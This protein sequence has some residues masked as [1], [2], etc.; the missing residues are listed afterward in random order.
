MVIMMP[1]PSTSYICMNDD[2]GDDENDV[3]DNVTS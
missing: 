3:N 2:D 1:L